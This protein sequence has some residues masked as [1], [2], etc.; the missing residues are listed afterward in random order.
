MILNIFI[1]IN[2]MP[3]WYIDRRVFVEDPQRKYN[4]KK[5]YQTQRITI[6]LNQSK[7]KKKD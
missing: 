2:I 7:K 1:H 6:L 3:A 5:K 4:P